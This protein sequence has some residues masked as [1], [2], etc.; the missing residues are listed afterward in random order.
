MPINQ[1]L[2]VMA[3][4]HEFKASLECGETVPKQ[5]KIRCSSIRWLFLGFEAT[6]GENDGKETGWSQNK[7]ELGRSVSGP[8]FKSPLSSQRSFL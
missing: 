1:E 3:Q 5:N 7:M 4:D 2:G 6:R 8:S